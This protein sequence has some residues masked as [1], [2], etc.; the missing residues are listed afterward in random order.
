M[1]RIVAVL[2]LVA[3]AGIA[4][5]VPR[6]T[7]EDRI[8]RRLEQLAEA[9]SLQPDES[10]IVRA[11]RGAQIGAFFTEDA[12]VDLGTP[13]QAVDGRDALVG[14]VAAALRLSAESITVTLTDL[15]VRFDRR[16]LLATGTFT[17]RGM[18]STGA[19]VDRR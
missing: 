1:R 9:A 14:L 13:F 16:L 11:A 8:V 17:A 7:E 4:W 12:R 5:T 19:E 18:S 2:G 15:S 3:V 6:P 10:P